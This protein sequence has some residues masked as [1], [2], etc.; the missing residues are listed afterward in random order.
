MEHIF[1]QPLVNA[2]IFFYQFL[3]QNLG[4]AIIGLT[5]VIREF[6]PPLLFPPWNPPKK[7]K[8]FNLS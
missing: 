7:L 2:L 1:Y 6:L 3:G 5:V 8:I 4:L